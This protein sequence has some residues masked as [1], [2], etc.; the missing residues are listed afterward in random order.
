M[1]H[2]ISILEQTFGI[3]NTD[4]DVMKVLR[5][6]ELACYIASLLPNPMGILYNNEIGTGDLRI[7]EFIATARESMKTTMKNFDVS[8]ELVS[9]G[10]TWVFN[11]H[12]K[13]K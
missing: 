9:L 3:A 5:E 11:Q 6:K 10:N 7:N 8:E 2:K 13:R 12:W 1:L 4:N